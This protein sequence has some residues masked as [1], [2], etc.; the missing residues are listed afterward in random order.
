MK[1]NDF[2]QRLND[3]PETLTF[4]D[5]IALIESLYDYTPVRFSNGGLVSE[6]GQNAGS[7]KIFSFAQLQ[8]LSPQQ[9][10]HCFGAYYREDVLKRPQGESHANIRN[11]MATGWDGIVFQGSALKVKSGKD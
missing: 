8:G 7:C 5:S 1:L 10:L 9:T 3:A 2:L 6:A 4:N 11:F